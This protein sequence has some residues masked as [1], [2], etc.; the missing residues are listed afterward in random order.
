MIN[1]LYLYIYS[2][3]Q[4]VEISFTESVALQDLFAIIDEHYTLRI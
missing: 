3:S 4:T 1:M 2:E